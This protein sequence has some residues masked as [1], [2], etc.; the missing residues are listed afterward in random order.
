[1]TPLDDRLRETL[2]AWLKHSLLSDRSF[3]DETLGD[4]GF[5]ASLKRGRRLT[6]GTADKVLAAMGK[7]PLGPAFAREV[8][9]F[10]LHSRTKPYVLGEGAAGDP[11]FVG[12]MRD[13]VS[14]RLA[15][16]DKVR[17]WMAGQADAGSREA[18]ARAVAGVG[19]LA[20]EGEAGD[21]QAETDMNH[22]ETPHLSARQAAAWLGISVRT[23]YRLREAGGGPDHFWFGRRILYR[24]DHLQSWAAACH[25]PGRPGAGGGR[26]A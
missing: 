12:R 21:P 13:G 26:D 2:D 19:L 24:R 8:E 18:M 7:P 5:V 11:S 23:L 20:P 3:G 14:F 17:A 16:V 9:A 6:L 10:L 22:D 4:P 15:T 1:M 25:V